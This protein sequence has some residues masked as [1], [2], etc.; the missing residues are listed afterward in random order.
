MTE[1]TSW[2][3][4][5]PAPSINTASEADMRFRF[6][7]SALATGLAAHPA[8]GGRPGVPREPDPATL[9]QGDWV[10]TTVRHKG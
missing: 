10:L 7:F 5:D 8:G 4:S 2:P 6:V 1:K 3:P 9:I